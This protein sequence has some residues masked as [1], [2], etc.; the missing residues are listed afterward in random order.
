[1][2]FSLYIYSELFSAFVECFALCVSMKVFKEFI[3]MQEKTAVK[4]EILKQEEKYKW[5]ILNGVK[6]EVIDL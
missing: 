4:E 5:A 2:L 3:L 1:M 6:K